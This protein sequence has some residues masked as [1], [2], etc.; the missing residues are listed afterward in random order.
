MT[1][2]SKAL[3]QGAMLKQR[4]ITAAILLLAFLVLL[5][6]VPQWLW[7]LLAGAVAAL[8]AREWVVMAGLKGPFAAVFVAGVG[9]L[10][11]L[12]GLLAGLSGS[13]VK[14]AWL[15]P[16]YVAAGVL[17]LCLVP[18]WMRAGQVPGGTCAGVLIGLG[19]L[20]PTAL[21]LAHLRLLD[22][23][24]LL[25]AMALVWVADIAAYFTGRAFGRRKLAPSI[26][27]GKTVEGALGAATAV[28]LVGLLLLSGFGMTLTALSVIVAVLALG[29][30]T[31]VSIEGDLFE[32]MLKRRAGIKDSGSLLPGHGG[33]LDRIDSLTSTLPL[34]AL[35]LIVF[36]D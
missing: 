26:S 20:V 30:L 13:T 28:V 23:W 6:F 22:P 2:R 29:V 32:S 19:V 3:A 10:S 34:I 35:L 18:F 24:L 17:W 27:P 25:A 5:F 8:A 12:L 1:V 14:A 4:V 11:L 33:I 7:L 15:V 16:G 21:A 36:G 31:A 9:L